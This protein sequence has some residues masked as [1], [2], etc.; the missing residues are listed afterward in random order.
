MPPMGGVGAT[1]LGSVLSYAW[2]KF[3]QNIGDW[4]VL[5]LVLIAVAIVSVFVDIAI[6]VGGGVGGFRVGLFFDPLGIVADVVFGIIEGIFLVAVAKAAVMVVN[7]RP[8][9]VAEAF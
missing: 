8:V 5:W 2:N 3:I 1:D 4:V 9:D 6:G 7:G